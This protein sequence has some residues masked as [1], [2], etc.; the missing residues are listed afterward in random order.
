MGS[1]WENIAFILHSLGAND[2][3]QIGY[4]TGHS[5][6]FLL[7]PLWINAFVYMTFA[8]MMWVF[9]PGDKRIGF[10]K[11]Q[12]ISKYFV[13]ADILTFIV[14]GVG[15]IMASPGADPNTIKIGLNIYLAGLG[16]QEFFILCFLGLMVTFH[17]QSLVLDASAAGSGA[18]VDGYGAQ[19]RRGWKGLLYTL[20][21][22]LSFISVRFL[23]LL[24]SVCLPS[25]LNLPRLT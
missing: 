3:Q 20:Y 2:Q 11:A 25:H 24:L 16:F 4:A 1:L 8:R 9:L 13:L 10:V 18:G 14:Q 22:V 5:L 6:L 12:S 15:G 19:P 21:A 7:A 17:R 23:C